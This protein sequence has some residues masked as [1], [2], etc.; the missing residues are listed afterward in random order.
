MK[1][2]VASFTVC[3]A[4]GA[5]GE[6][7]FAQPAPTPENPD[8][9]P[10]PAPKETAPT[11]EQMAAAR[12]HYAKGRAAQ[13]AG[14]FDVASEEYLAA[15]DAYPQPLLLYNAAQAYRLGGA[16]AKAIEFYDKYL[17]LD[18]DGQGAANSREIVAELRASLAEDKP[19]KPVDPVEPKGEPDTKPAKPPEPEIVI[20][21]LDP[22][23]PKAQPAMPK[24]SSG[25]A[26]KIVG[27][28][29]AGVGLA[30]IGAGVF[31]GLRA[32]S[33]SDE[34]SGFEGPWNESQ[35]QLYDDGQSAERLMFIS[36][37]VG[38]AAVVTGGVLYLMGARRDSRAEVLHVGVNGDAVSF[39]ITGSY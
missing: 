34:I 24:P 23:K 21:L 7:L 33:K 25:K 4:L 32:Q 18:P 37:T 29:T 13:D 36:T 31:F 2:L 35:N 5:G 8:A 38:A 6:P 19:P 28:S 11:P 39:S 10:A 30:A 14:E 26:L 20:P 1:A 16:I 27:L 3:L 15:Y 22:E 17:D 12:D 9:K